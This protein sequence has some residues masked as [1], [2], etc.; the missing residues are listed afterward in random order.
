MSNRQHPH[1]KSITTTP[2]GP[3]AAAQPVDSPAVGEPT[4]VAEG[5]PIAVRP[6]P[7][8]DDGR[9]SAAWLHIVAPPSWSVTPSARSWCTCGYERHA[10]G[11]AAVLQLVA[12][13][14]EHRIACPLLTPDSEGRT[15]A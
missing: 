11:R 12:A 4:G 15:A 14:G 1:L 8:K 13:H 7:R 9:R 6:D 5:V 2:D 10:I 3:P